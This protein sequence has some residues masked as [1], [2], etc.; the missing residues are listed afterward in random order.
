[1]GDLALASLPPLL[2]QVIDGR[3][4]R[5]GGE[6]QRLLAAAAVIGQ[7]VPLALWAAVGQAGEDAFLEAVAAAVEAR[8][9]AA[10]GDD[11]GVRFA[12]ALV[13]EALYE[14]LPPG[15]RRAWHR[16]VAEALQSAPDP[17][18]DAVA[19]HLR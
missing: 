13:R 6:A 16:R 2:R 19:Y 4:A 7:E 8:L 15:R 18:P 14:G 3:V 1:L 11:A 12:H 10:A 17:D 9:L 5:L